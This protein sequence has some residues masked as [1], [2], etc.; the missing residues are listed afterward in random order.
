MSRDHP[1]QK[2]PHPGQDLSDFPSSTTTRRALFRA[3][4]KVNGPGY[5]ASDDGGRFN[6]STPRGTNYFADD[7]YTAVRERLGE[8][9]SDG[10]GIFEDKADEMVVSVAVLPSGRKYANV[11]HADAADHHVT[12]E[13]CAGYDYAVYQEWATAFDAAGFAGVRYASRFTTAPGP[14]SWAQFGPEGPSTTL[15][16]RAAEQLDGVTACE[17]AKVKILHRGPKSSFSMVT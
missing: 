17:K 12:R 2:P 10:Q 1:A 16:T 9:V 8:L 13:L 15:T 11:T 7:V 4:A 14:N 3:H 6:L 5:F